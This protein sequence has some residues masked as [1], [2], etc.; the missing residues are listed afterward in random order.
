MAILTGAQEILEELEARQI[1]VRARGLDLELV[2]PRGALPTALAEEIRRHKE[3]LRRLVTLRG[4]P[5][6][7][8]AS[9]RQFRTPEARLYPFINLT[10][11]TPQGRGRLL[12][13][14]PDRAAVA[15]E[16]EGR[17]TVYLL[18][19]EIRPPGLASELNEPFETV[20]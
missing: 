6:E 13:V 18:P 9:V 4:W 5:E 19:S 12:E 8:A 3:E 16:R 17:R 11:V 2:G 20:H 1:R 10:V 7:S 15:L 14:L